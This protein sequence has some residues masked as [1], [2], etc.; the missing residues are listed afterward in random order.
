MPT[1]LK[2]YEAIASEHRMLCPMKLVLV[3]ASAFMLLSLGVRADD[4][5]YNNDRPRHSDYDRDRADQWHHKH[6]HKIMVRIAP[7]HVNRDRD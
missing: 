6:H 5:Y 2:W 3:F 1:K 4:V 7:E